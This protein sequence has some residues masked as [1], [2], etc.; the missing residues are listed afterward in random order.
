[1][2]GVVFSADGKIVSSSWDK[3]IKLWQVDTGKLIETLEGHAKEIVS[4]TIS[5]DGKTIVSG[6]ADGSIKVWQKRS[7]T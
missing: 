2:T 7:L 3:T 1:V 5:L 6:S 4:T